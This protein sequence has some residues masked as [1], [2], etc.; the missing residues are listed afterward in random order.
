M[1]GKIMEENHRGPMA[2]HFSGHR[3]FYTLSH[4]WWWE[5]M[6]NDAQR[7]VNGCPECAIAS[8]GGRV[9]R[10]PL[11]PIP[12]SRPFQI[13][14]VDVMD[15]PKTALANQHVLV[16]QDL[17]TKWP[18]VFAIPDQ[19]T[20]RIVRILVHEIIPFCGVPEALLSDRGTNLLSHLMMD[21]CELLG[22]RKLNTT[23]CNPQ[24][25][26]LVERY[27]PT[28]K[29]ALRKHTARYRYGVQWDRMLPEKFKNKDRK[30]I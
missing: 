6:Y 15:L 9:Q 4:H 3:P 14:G 29:T 5:G 8:G 27:N 10:P 12:V 22:I 21:T 11:H 17:Y 28:L 20:E 19:K 16:F 23:A 24:C 18:I 7:Y 1:R 13:I 26:G 30:V 2:R 25:D